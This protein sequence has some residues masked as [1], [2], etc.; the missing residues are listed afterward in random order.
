MLI[1]TP[2]RPVTTTSAYMP[3]IAPPDWASA[4]SLAEARGAD[5]ELG[6]DRQDQRHRGGQPHAGH[7]VRQGGG[8]DDV[9]DPGQPA[10]AEGAGGV[11]GDRVDV[12]HAVEHLDQHLP[13]R[14]RRRPAAAWTRASVP[15]SSTASGISATDGIGRRNSIGGVGGLPQEV[16]RADDQAEHHGGRHGDQE[17]QEPGLHRVA[18]GHPEGREPEV[19]SRAAMTSLAG[20]RYAGST[21]PSRGMSSQ[22]SRNRGPPPGPAVVLLVP[23]GPAGAAAPRSGAAPPRSGL[24]ITGGVRLRSAPWQRAVAGGGLAEGLEGVLVELDAV[25]R[26]HDLGAG[27]SSILV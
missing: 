2:S 12:G 22:V 14:R 3:A 11:V 26:Q 7:Q 13:E 27:A 4:I 10:Q 9:A 24:G 5:D 8:P 17:A 15:N 23:C 21:M 16:A 18:H 1:S 19:D 25:P 20:G 6:G